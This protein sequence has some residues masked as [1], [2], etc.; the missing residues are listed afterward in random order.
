[1]NFAPAPEK[2]L[3]WDLNKWAHWD[4]DIEDIEI[5]PSGAILGGQ[6]CY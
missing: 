6:L 3:L 1:M 5:S 4:D 2:G